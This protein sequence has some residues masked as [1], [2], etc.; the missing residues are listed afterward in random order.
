MKATENSC[1]EDEEDRETA[2]ND[3]KPA[4]E[5]PVENNEERPEENANDEQPDD[6]KPAEDKEEDKEEVIKEEVLNSA[7]TLGT[8]VGG[9]TE[10]RNLTGSAFWKYLDDH[11]IR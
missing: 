1:G 4:E 10:W 3:D 9:G 7:S 2:N 11:N 5:K 6:E 8:S